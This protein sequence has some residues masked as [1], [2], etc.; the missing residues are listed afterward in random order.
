MTQWIAFDEESTAFAARHTRAAVVFQSGDAI[1]LALAADR[2]PIIILPTNHGN[3]RLTLLRLR[4]KT[5]QTEGESVVYEPTGI[6][7]LTD[8]ISFE[9]QPQA[10]KNWWRRLLE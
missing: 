8:S 3:E 2:A 10:S 7:G 5:P 6:L 1:R 4:R 9:R